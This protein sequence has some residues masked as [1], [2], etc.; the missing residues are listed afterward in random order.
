[1][2]GSFTMGKFQFEKATYELEINDGKAYTIDFSDD[3]M[4]RYTDMAEDI[5]KAYGGI[6]EEDFLKMNKE[7]RH[8]L[9]SQQ[10]ESMK[11]VI[12][13]FL[14]DSA[15]DEVYELAGRSLGNLVPLI[16]HIMDEFE[17]RNSGRVEAKK[18]QYLKKK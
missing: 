16:M 11:K 8:E 13:E 17:K 4:M 9:L 14:G 6:S 7:E 1:M 15:F 5:Q 10:R 2:K 3:A 12:N 18:A